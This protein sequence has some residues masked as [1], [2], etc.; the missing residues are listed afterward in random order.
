MACAS[1]TKLYKRKQLLTSNCYKT[2]DKNDRKVTKQKVN[3]QNML[4]NHRKHIKQENI[5][6]SIADFVDKYVQSNL[7]H[8]LV[9]PVI[10]FYNIK[11]LSKSRTEFLSK[12]L[13]SCNLNGFYNLT[14]Y[15]KLLEMSEKKT[16]KTSIFFII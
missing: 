5:P 8:A 10:L 7:V 2:N 13:K 9:N 4:K 16:T 14:K 12:H 11:S 3:L 1:I 15:W 6:P